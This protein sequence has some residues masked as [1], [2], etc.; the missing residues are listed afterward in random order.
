MGEAT[1]KTTGKKVPPV[2]P[3]A[4]TWIW[5]TALV[6]IV[7]G[8]P[9]ALLVWGAMA[10][11]EMGK[12]QPMDCAEA[13]DW[14]NAT[15]PKSARD[16]HCTVSNWLDTQVNAEFRMPRAEVAGWLAGTYPG[17]EVRSYCQTDL[18]V[19]VQETP[20]EPG[21]PAA[22]NV[23]VTYEDGGTALVHVMP[24]TV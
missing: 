17:G 16:P 15:M 13:M 18:C 10:W 8:G 12:P 23:T 21:G 24:F 20:P 6:S 2:R 19:D 5:V 22:V 14:A 4:S 7:C 11:D 3:R 1:G 9:L